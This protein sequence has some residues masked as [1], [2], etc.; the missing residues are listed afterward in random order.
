MSTDITQIK[1]A[2]LVDLQQRFEDLESLLAGQKLSLQCAS[3]P[4]PAGRI[5]PLMAEIK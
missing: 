5:A 3:I 4:T 1:R 2:R